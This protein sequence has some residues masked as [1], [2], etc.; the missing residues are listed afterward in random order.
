MS[1]KS[2]G[3]NN[4]KYIYFNWRCI[5]TYILCIIQN[6]CSYISSVYIFCVAFAVFLKQN[7]SML[8]YGEFTAVHEYFPDCA[9]TTIC[10]HGNTSPFCIILIKWLCSSTAVLCSWLSNSLDILLIVRSS[11]E[12]PEISILEEENSYHFSSLSISLSNS[13]FRV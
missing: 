3:I 1:V 12:L 9:C 5:F 6:V 7:F 11:A 2:P 10:S 4:H 8:R 13:H